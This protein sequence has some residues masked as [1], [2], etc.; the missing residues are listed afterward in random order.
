MNFSFV[1]LNKKFTEN[2]VKFGI[3]IEYDFRITITTVT[4]VYF[5]QL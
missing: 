2:V 4:V 1:N 3:R 5:Y